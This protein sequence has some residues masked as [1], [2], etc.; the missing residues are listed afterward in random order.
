[1]A[2]VVQR[3]QAAPERG[4]HCE[5]EGHTLPHPQ[6]QPADTQGGPGVALQA[7]LP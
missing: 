3:A 7:L 6:G 5:H 4:T 2:G 1:M